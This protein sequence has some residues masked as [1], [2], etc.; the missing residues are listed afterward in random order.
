[1]LDAVARTLRLDRAERWHLYRRAEAM[2]VRANPAP[3]A[4]PDA[5]REILR[6]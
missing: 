3:A 5:I 1:V 4:I 6:T 2:P